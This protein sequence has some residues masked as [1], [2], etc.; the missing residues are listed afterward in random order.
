MGLEKKKQK[1]LAV[2][3]LG[4]G[5]GEKVPQEIFLIVVLCFKSVCY[6]KCAN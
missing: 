3:M 1:K 5:G 2:I 4:T 6:Q